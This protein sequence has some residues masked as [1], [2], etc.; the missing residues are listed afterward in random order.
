MIS[1]L[2]ITKNPQLI[3]RFVIVFAVLIFYDTVWDTVLTLSH[4][5][6]ML[7]HYLFE[8]CEHTLDLFI[9]HLFH[10]DP[11]TTEII[12]FYIMAFIIG[13]LVLLLIMALPNWYCKACERLMNYWQE[14]KTKAVEKWQ[15]QPLIEKIKWGS[16][17][18]AGSVVMI[19]WVL[20]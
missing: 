9:E 3:V 1:P 18:I 13:C 4:S 7:L 12:V 6:L 8:F 19:F 5:F 15:N 10:T 2:S 14:E 17:L 16:A 11:R 20:N